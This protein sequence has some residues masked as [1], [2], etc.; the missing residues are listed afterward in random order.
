MCGGRPGSRRRPW[1]PPRPHLPRPAVAGE[2]LERFHRIAVPV[3]AV[4]EVRLHPGRPAGEHLFPRHAQRSVSAALAD[5]RVVV[6]NGARQ[7]RIDARLLPATTV[8]G[9]GAVPV[10]PRDAVAGLEV[11]EAAQL[12][13][14]TGQ[15]VALGPAG[16]AVEVRAGWNRIDGALL[17]SGRHRWS[18]DAVPGGGR[19]GGRGPEAGRTAPSPGPRRYF[20]CEP[21][22]HD[23]N[24]HPDKTRCWRGGRD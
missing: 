17:P 10:D 8:R 21:L 9:R 18:I 16:F 11:L 6:I 2:L 22:R 1:R 4:V 13:A 5:T 14:A 23:R 24:I 15:V 20:F 7:T 3:A 19:G 12:S